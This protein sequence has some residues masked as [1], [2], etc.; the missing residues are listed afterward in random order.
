MFQTTD[1]KP[2]EAIGVVIYRRLA[3]PFVSIFVR[4]KISPNIITIFTLLMALVTFN[5]MMRDCFILAAFSWQFVPLFDVCD[6]IVAR[7]TGKSSLF[8]A[9]LDYLID[10]VNYNI[11]IIGMGISMGSKDGWMLIFAVIVLAHLNDVA[12]LKGIIS[13]TCSERRVSEHGQN[14]RSSQKS[15]F[16]N[17]IQWFVSNFVRMHIH[18]WGFFGF[19]LVLGKNYI[20]YI[21][22]LMI[23]ALAANILLNIREQLH[24]AKIKMS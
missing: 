17:G 10:R 18:H 2:G 15:A 3:L 4:M 22:F 21:P 16:R 12:T 11:L 6:G 23:A 8:G 7:R 9:W 20:Q 1:V 24:M 5:L 13:N 19:L 14:L